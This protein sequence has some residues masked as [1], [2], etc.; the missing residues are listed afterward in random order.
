MSKQT[1]KD[2]SELL[3][4]NNFNSTIFFSIKNVRLDKI[5]NILKIK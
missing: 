4:K 1:N 5:I 2:A 3:I